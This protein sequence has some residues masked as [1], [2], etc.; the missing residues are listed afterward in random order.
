MNFFNGMEGKFS[1]SHT[2]KDAKFLFKLKILQILEE[3]F[4]HPLSEK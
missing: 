3:I 4:F 2:Q 1:T